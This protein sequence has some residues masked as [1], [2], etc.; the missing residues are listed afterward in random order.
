MAIGQQYFQWAGC[1]HQGQTLLANRYAVI[2][3]LELP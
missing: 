1:W 3:L 2:I